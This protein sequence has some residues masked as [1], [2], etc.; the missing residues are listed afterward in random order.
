MPLNIVLVE[1]EIPQ[2]TGNIARTCAAA[3]AVLHLVE[4]LGFSIEDRYLKRAGLDYWN[5]V[6]VHLY[7]SLDEFFSKCRGGDFF[8][9]TTKAEKS[10]ADA[11]IPDGSYLLFGKETK[12]LPEE[13]LKA[14]YG[15]CIRIPMVSDAR[16]LNISNA[17]AIVLYDALRKLEFPGL[18]A[19]G[20]PGHF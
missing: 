17:A 5:L 19:D 15:R 3:G 20:K 9:I 12:G 1:P 8:Y 14:N 2:N 18:K 16:S 4:P 7:G 13:L 6:D 10:Y 11:E